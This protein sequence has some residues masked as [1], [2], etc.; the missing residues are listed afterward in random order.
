MISQ[1]NKKTIHNI[2][3]QKILL[4][5]INSLNLRN[6]N[7]LKNKFHKGMFAHLFQWI[8]RKYKILS[9]R[10]KISQMRKN[11]YKI[12]QWALEVNRQHLEWL[13]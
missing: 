10:D 7:I 9:K 4:L 12:I 8:N 1:F 5:C 2:Q 6:L 13:L 11:S 3:D